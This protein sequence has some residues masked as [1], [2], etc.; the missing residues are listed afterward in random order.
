MTTKEPQPQRSNRERL[1]AEILCSL[2]AGGG[3]DP[4]DLFDEDGDDRSTWHRARIL[5]VAFAMADALV[6]RCAG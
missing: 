2:L 6:A 4:E 1:A 3:V 5:D